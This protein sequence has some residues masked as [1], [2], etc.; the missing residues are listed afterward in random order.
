MS[1]SCVHVPSGCNA[2]R[3]ACPATRTDCAMR[4]RSG[5]PCAE[6]ERMAKTLRQRF[7]R[8]NEQK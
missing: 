5:E 6:M 4:C 8:N 3:A 7:S 1:K 2:P